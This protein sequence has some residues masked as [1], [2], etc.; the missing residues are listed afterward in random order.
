[1]TRIRTTAAA[2]AAA[3]LLAATGCGDGES[4]DEGTGG[5]GTQDAPLNEEGTPQQNETTP[6]PE[7]SELG[8]GD[9][10]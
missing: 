2:F 4:T 9:E 10:G 7:G 1:M 8:S 3:L 5:T 6:A